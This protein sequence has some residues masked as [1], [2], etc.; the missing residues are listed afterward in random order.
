MKK[1][2]EKFIDVV[3]AGMGSCQCGDCYCR[4]FADGTIEYQGIERWQR[5]KRRMTLRDYNGGWIEPTRRYHSEL[6]ELEYL[7][8]MHT[9]QHAQESELQDEF[10]EERKRIFRSINKGETTIIKEIARLQQ[11]L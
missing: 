11:S 6:D 5:S 1:E 7:L 4:V 10:D 3:T 9:L 2:Q 8:A